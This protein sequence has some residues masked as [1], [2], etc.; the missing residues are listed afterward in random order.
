MNIYPLASFLQRHVYKH[1]HEK[2]QQHKLEISLRGYPLTVKASGSPRDVEICYIGF[3]VIKCDFNIF[4]FLCVVI[5]L[6]VYFENGC[7]GRN[8]YP[9]FV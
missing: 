9:D 8:I 5:F 2:Y 3:P 4:I 7:V 6:D 1:H